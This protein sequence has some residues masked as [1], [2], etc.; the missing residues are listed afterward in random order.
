MVSKYYNIDIY[1]VDY[2]LY[3]EVMGDCWHS[4]PTVYICE[5][6]LNK[7]QKKRV[8]TDKR[9]ETFMI[10]NY[11]A[12]MLYLWENDINNNIEVCSSIID[13]FIKAKGKLSN[14]HSFNYCLSNE[15]ELCLSVDICY[16]YHKKE[17]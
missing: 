13:E 12:N 5:D 15:D 16:P 2:D 6:R 8:I 10:N 11:T 14:Y 17:L 9:K 7:I 3:I 1:L 4:N